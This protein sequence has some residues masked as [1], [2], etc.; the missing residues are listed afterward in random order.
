MWRAISEL[1]ASSLT[2]MPCGRTSAPRRHGARGG[3]TMKSSRYRL[4]KSVATQSSSTMMRDIAP[5]PLSRASRHRSEEHTSELQSLMRN[6]YA[7]LCL[8]NKNDDTHDKVTQFKDNTKI[9]N[10]IT[11]ATTP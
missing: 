11:S 9:K 7:V 6:S 3:S 4:R 8:K 2:P 5:T 1:R 10:T